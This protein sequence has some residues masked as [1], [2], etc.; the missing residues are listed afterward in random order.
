[1]EWLDENIAYWH[2]LVFGIALAVLEIFVP[3]FF[4]LWLGV[5]AILVGALLV[6]VDLSFTLQLS[7]WVIFSILTTTL[8][9]RL[10]SPRMKDKSYSGMAKE[11]IT[12]QV[13]NITE[14]NPETNQG[15]IRFHIPILGDTEWP[16]IC[17]DE[18]KSGDRGRIIELSGNKLIIKKH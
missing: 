1:M 6:F 5:S 17:E 3:A 18:V 15:I 4:M 7:L 10:I 11:A 16:F 2:W 8:W 14:F 12:G 13:G 9:F